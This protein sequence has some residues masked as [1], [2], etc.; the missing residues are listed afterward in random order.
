MSSSEVNPPQAGTSGKELRA[1]SDKTREE[2][3]GKVYSKEV[4]E[5]VKKHLSD[6][7]AMQAKAK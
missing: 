5:Q 7:R 2:L 4:Y 1:I 3:A 6:Y